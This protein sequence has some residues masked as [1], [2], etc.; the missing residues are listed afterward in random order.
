MKQDMPRLAAAGSVTA[1]TSAMSAERPEVMNCFTPFSTQPLP[2]RSARVRRFEAS[3]PACGSVRQKAPNTSPQDRKSTR[4]N[5]SHLGISYAVFC[6]KK[7][8]QKN[9]IYQPGA[10]VTS[11]VL[12]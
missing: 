1:K 12:V 8:K 3:E 2:R 5:S 7:K 4:L 11:H 9:I 10:A 6:L